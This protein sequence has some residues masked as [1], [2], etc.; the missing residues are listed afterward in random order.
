M[1]LVRHKDHTGFYNNA[2]DDNTE[3]HERS[4]VRKKLKKERKER[5]AKNE[6]K[7]N[8]ADAQ[9]E[10]NGAGLRS[11]RHHVCGH[12]CYSR[13]QL[14]TDPPNKSPDQQRVD[15]PGWGLLE[16][17]LTNLHMQNRITGWAKNQSWEVCLGLMALYQLLTLYC[18][19][20]GRENGAV[21]Q[22]IINKFC[23]A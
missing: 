17:D 9:H 7:K 14:G 2:S 1:S 23:S 16:R 19:A 20:K 11:R 4:K 13:V 3:K 22:E 8:A 12:R 18:I 5:K 15:I 6:S 10:L 21:N